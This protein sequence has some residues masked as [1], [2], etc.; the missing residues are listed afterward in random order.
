[1]SWG[2]DFTANVFIK[3]KLIKTKAD[4]ESELDYAQIMNG[5]N[6][7]GLGKSQKEQDI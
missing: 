4:A 6:M 5:L 3:N 1:M 2:T 7:I